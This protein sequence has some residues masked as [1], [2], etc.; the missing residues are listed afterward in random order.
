MPTLPG[1]REEVGTGAEQLGGTALWAAQ[2][3]GTALWLCEGIPHFQACLRSP[4]VEELLCATDRPVSGAPGRGVTVSH[5][6]A[7]L[8]SPRSYCVPQTASI[9]GPSPSAATLP[10]VAWSPVWL[11][12][13]ELNLHFP[14]YCF[15]YPKLFTVLFCYNNGTKSVLL[16]LKII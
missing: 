11:P 8:R 15:A 9:R 16:F 6:Q 12:I 4:Q 1:S 7:C 10:R 2:L 13:C 5:R 14:Y 3:G